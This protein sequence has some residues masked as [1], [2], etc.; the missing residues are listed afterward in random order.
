MVQKATETIKE[1]QFPITLGTLITVISITIGIAFNVSS[2]KG[3]MEI[4]HAKMLGRLTAQ[5]ERCASTLVTLA[6]HEQ[7]LDET[8]VQYGRIEEKMINIEAMVAR[9][10]VSLD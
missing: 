6:N 1:K 5:E 8:D 2:V 10:L 9:I 4:E 3:E 7:R